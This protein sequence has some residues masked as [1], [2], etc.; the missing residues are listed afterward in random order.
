MRL[1]RSRT[2]ALTPVVSEARPAP[3][4]RQSATASGG[5]PLVVSLLRR[6]LL[7]ASVASCRSGAR[8]FVFIWSSRAT[9]LHWR[10]VVARGGSSC[11]A[12]A[13]DCCERAPTPSSFRGGPHS[14]TGAVVARG[15]SSLSLRFGL[16]V[17]LFCCA[18]GL[19]SPSM[20]VPRKVWL[21]PS[22]LCLGGLRV[23]AR[24]VI[25]GSGVR[26][27]CSGVG[28]LL[29]CGARAVSELL[30]SGRAPAPSRLSFGERGPHAPSGGSGCPGWFLPFG[31]RYG[32]VALFLLVGV[33][34]WGCCFG[35]RGPFPFGGRCCVGLL[36]AGSS[37]SVPA[38]ATWTFSFWK[39]LLL[40]QR[41]FRFLSDSA[42]WIPF[43]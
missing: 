29:R 28:W 13:F 19:P 4:S 26:P 32:N 40:R 12:G 34:A 20:A 18:T 7:R 10:P 31:S 15:G 23:Q 25:S 43:G 2:S 42:T 3:S 27:V 33:A 16:V 30:L 14:S 37:R 39:P 24:E 35:K 41:V 17:V 6:L 38:T 5:F 36:R 1:L 11:P 8:P 9:Y 21:A 22:R